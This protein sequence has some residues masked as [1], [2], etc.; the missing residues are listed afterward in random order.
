MFFRHAL[1][2]IGF[3]FAVF[4]IVSAF[5]FVISLRIILNDTVTPHFL[6]IILTLYVYSNLISFKLIFL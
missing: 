2:Q 3:G 6:P 1:A 4:T 5:T